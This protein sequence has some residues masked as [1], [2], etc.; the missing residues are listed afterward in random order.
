M[1]LIALLPTGCDRAQEP[2]LSAKPASTEQVKRT[3]DAREPNY[4]GLIEEYRAVMS[5][6]PG[7]IANIIALGN[8]YFD[9]GRW[10]KAINIF[11][12][13]LRLDPRNADVRTDMGTAYR[14]LGM[15][16]RALAEY[17]NVLHIE[18]GHLNSRFNL[19]IVYA[20]DKKNH[21]AAIHVWEELLKIAPNHPKAEF[22]RSA[23]AAFKSGRGTGGEAR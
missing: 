11:A 9:S 23:I 17:N 18:P 19:G 14:N 21:D 4:D 15:T 3:E 5:E 10:E 12:H 13:A 8:A 1:L 2:K 6:D 20:Y 7:N 16:E 22:M